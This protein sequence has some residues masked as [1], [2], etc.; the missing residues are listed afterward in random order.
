M[1]RPVEDS[2]S[3]LTG[4]GVGAVLALLLDP[5]VGPKRRGK[6][7]KKTRRAIRSSEGR[8][9]GLGHLAYDRAGHAA[10]DAADYARYAKRRALKAGHDAWDTG[11]EWV[12]SLGDSLF[13]RYA[14]AKGKARRYAKSSVNTGRAATVSA[15]GLFGSLL[16]HFGDSALEKATQAR[17][18]AKQKADYFRSQAKSTGKKAKNRA[19]DRY[20][21]LRENWSEPESDDTVSHL[22]VGIGLVGLG[23][24]LAYLFDTAQGGP[25]RR[26]IVEKA[27]LYARV[28]VNGIVGEAK[29]VGNRASGLAHDAAEAVSK[30]FSGHEAVDDE[31]LAAR[32]RSELGHVVDDVEALGLTVHDG[33]VTLT[34]V[35]PDKQ[36]AVMDRLNAI[37]GVRGVEGPA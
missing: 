12:E 17:K 21:S 4:L 37:S 25:R 8:L 28:A 19:Q 3:L 18:L 15:G 5:T 36:Q 1:K 7:A 33:R 29:N 20:D 9:T 2:L 22:I 6:I 16:G 27:D 14:D 10:S 32:A 35:P 34:S 23:A 13:D 11:E 31:T 24:G 30:T 26:R